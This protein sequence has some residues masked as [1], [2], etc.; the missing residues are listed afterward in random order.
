[1][2]ILFIGDIVG[3]PGREAV[4]NLLNKMISDYRVEFTIANGENAA[5]GMGVTPDIARE[6]LGQGVDVL[7]SGNHIWA[8]KEILPFLEVEKRLLRP[9]NYPPQV[10][11]RGVGLF[12]S[13]NGEKIG[14]INLEGRVF[15]KHLD[16]PFRTVEREVEGLRKEAHIILVDF[17][18]EAT[19]EKIA[20]GWFLDGRVT[21]VIGTHTHVQTSDEKILEGGTAYIT[22]VGMT[23]PQDSVIGIRKQV[24]LNRLLTQIPWKYDVATGSTELQGVLIEVDRE[25]GKSSD[26][27]RI[28]VPLSARNEHHEP[29]G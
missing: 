18:A 23:G 3:K 19:S 27:Q 1:M 29:K 9:A 17:H 6:L 26:I 14:V 24:A 20:M 12:P 5:G 2:K 22:D 21:A 15:M 4:Q 7:T 13:R 25:T 28:K 8:K 11:G 10:P 16:C